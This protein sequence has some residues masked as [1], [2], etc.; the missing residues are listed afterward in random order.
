MGAISNRGGIARKLQE[1]SPKKTIRR[2]AR[3]GLG[4]Y[5]G[6]GRL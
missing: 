2:L 1:S 3:E 5:V 4:R 6:A